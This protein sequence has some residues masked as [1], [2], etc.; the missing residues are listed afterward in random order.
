MNNLKIGGSCYGNKRNNGMYVDKF[1]IF[2]AQVDIDAL[3]DTI[4]NDFIPCLTRNN[5]WVSVWYI[6]KDH[7]I[8][9][10]K[11]SRS[12]FDKQMLEWFPEVYSPN[13]LNTYAATILSCTRWVN[14]NEEFFEKFKKRHKKAIK[15]GRLSISTAENIYYLC[16]QFNS[17]IKKKC[18]KKNTQS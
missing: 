14:W 16:D 2:T 8:L 13:C 17:I 4:L 6:L 9:K 3:H 11:I 15:D 5:M 18:I 1:D 10:K 7:N 12:S